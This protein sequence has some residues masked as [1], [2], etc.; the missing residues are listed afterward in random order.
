M[1]LET[2]WREILHDPLTFVDDVKLQKSLI[3]WTEKSYNVATSDGRI[4]ANNAFRSLF[5]A[6]LKLVPPDN[7]DSYLD[8]RNRLGSDFTSTLTPTVILENF[9]Q[10]RHND[11]LSSSSHRDCFEAL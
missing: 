6:L 4:N 5:Q 1:A 9:D 11:G 2:A 10:S 7:V 3:T 8:L